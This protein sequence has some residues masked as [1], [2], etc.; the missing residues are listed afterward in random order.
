M[1]VA[2]VI[3]QLG[4]FVL[5][6]SLGFQGV[7][8]AQNTWLQQYGGTS[9]ELVSCS[10]RD[11]KDGIY[12]IGTFSGTALFG[13]F[14][15][16]TTGRG[17]VFVVKSS[18]TTGNVLWVR[19]IGSTGEDNGYGITCDKS[20]NVYCTG[21]F[22]G[23]VS[24]GMQVLT[25]SGPSDGFVAR[26][27][28]ATGLI[29][30]AIKQGGLG[31]DAGMVLTADSAGALYASG[32]FQSQA[33]FGMITLSASGSNSKTYLLK[34]D[35]ANGSIQWARAFGSAGYT[36][37]L[38]MGCS[39]SGDLYL[40]GQF[41]GS[42]LVGTSNLSAVD[43]NDGFVTKI[44]TVSG[45]P[46]WAIS[47][48]GR[49]EDIASALTFDHEGRLFV[50]GRFDDTLSITQENLVSSGNAD[51]F[52]CQLDTASGS[53][54]WQR[55]FGGTGFDQ[56]N[57][58]SADTKGNLFA[59]GLFNGIC[60]FG[61]TSFS[62]AGNSD[63]FVCRLTN[64]G[65]VNWSYRLGST[66]SDYGV[67]ILADDLG[68]FYCVGNFQQSLRFTDQYIAAKGSSDVFILKVDQLSLGMSDLS[69][70][71]HLLHV[72]PNPASTSL[73]LNLQALNSQEARIK[74]YDLQGKE[75]LVSIHSFDLNTI[76]LN[77]SDLAAGVY[78]LQI[79]L[80]QMPLQTLRFV[81]ED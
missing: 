38:S 18:A 17:D 52:I 69:A 71:D 78:V 63:V 32:I 28:P 60:Y 45:I 81:K 16:P 67:S 12:T 57:A 59:I 47:M 33:S 75:N 53:P 61:Q 80:G 8:W 68:S 7:T 3:R 2:G 34:V 58:L 49:G 25:A 9:S 11:G 20:G 15:L 65:E 5:P 29:K 56:L 22:N 23:S 54:L 73:Y 50:G 70:A 66:Q 24:F 40:A 6:F 41:D 39:R 4:W 27:D 42:M 1:N 44:N 14:Q 26:L 13:P 79:G 72:F 10:A 21:R 19:Q 51:A 36:F 74:I 43:F 76:Q 77:I 48:G 62:S 37:P 55:A 31:A 64:S 35:T 30:W 46:V